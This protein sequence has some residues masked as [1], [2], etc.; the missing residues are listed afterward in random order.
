M[1]ETSRNTPAIEVRDLVAGYNRKIILNHITFSVPR[2]QIVTVLGGSGCGKSTLLKHIIG[3]YRPKSG[4]TLIQGRSIVDSGEEE[5]RSIMQSFGVAYQG[6]ALFRS[7]TLAENIALPLQEYTS[8]TKSEIAEKVEEKLS[9][10]NLGGRGGMMPADLSGGM[11]K[12]AAFAR[13]LALD[14]AILFFDEP[15][16]GL[17]PLSSASLDRLI[18]DIRERTG[19]TILVVTHE[20]GSIFTIADRAIMLSA[21][22]R[23]IIADGPPKELRDHSENTFVRTFL[24]CGITGRDSN[25]GADHHA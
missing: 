14:P 19:A 20:L 2:G 10:V 25:T 16:A 13:A 21:E 22:T 4:D 1:D 12:R 9:L 17:D 24:N 18:L 3:L 23:N 7:L 11:I 6:G 8:L 5:R 15:S